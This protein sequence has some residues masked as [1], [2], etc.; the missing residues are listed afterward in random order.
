VVI[1][2]VFGTSVGMKVGVRMTI[3]MLDASKMYG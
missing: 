1:E 2:L 3:E